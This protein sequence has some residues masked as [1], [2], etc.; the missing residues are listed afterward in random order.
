[1]QKWGL[2]YRGKKKNHNPCIVQSKGLFSTQKEITH[3]IQYNQMK[4]HYSQQHCVSLPNVFMKRKI[5]QSWMLCSTESEARPPFLT[6]SAQAFRLHLVQLRTCT[7][8]KKQSHAGSSTVHLH[9]K[10]SII[11]HTITGHMQL[12]GASLIQ[13]SGGKGQFLSAISVDSGCVLILVGYF[14]L[15]TLA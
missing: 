2:N 4:P 10:A 3:P 12:P 15:N 1:M 14:I 6:L 11:S 8:P 7:E 9:C 13:A 5:G